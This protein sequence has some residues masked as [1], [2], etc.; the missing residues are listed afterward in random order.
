MSV[1][2]HFAAATL[3]FVLL[4]LWALNFPYHQVSDLVGSTFPWPAK[5]STLRIASL[6][7]EGFLAQAAVCIPVGLL[8]FLVVREKA[9]T[10]AVGLAAVFWLR[11]LYDLAFRYAGDLRMQWFAA[12]LAVVHLVLIVGTVLLVSH[13]SNR[14]AHRALAKNV[15]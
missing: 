6:L 10:L 13:L 7:L 2:R 1:L 11:V 4:V 8:V 12:Y 5:G 3:A 15:V 14:K 9:T